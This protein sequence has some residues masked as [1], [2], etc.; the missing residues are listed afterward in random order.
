MSAM[1]S[2]GSSAGSAIAGQFIDRMGSHGGFI[3]VTALALS[4]LVIAFLGFHQIKTSTEQ[5][6]LTEVTV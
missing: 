6:T 4:S 1:N 2:I 3:V 5:P